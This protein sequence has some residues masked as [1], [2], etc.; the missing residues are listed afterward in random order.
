MQRYIYNIHCL[1]YD[2]SEKFL[3]RSN[4]IF[5]TWILTLQKS[6][7]RYPRTLRKCR[8]CSCRNNLFLENWIEIVTSLWPHVT[9]IMIITITSTSST[10]NVPRYIFLKFYTEKFFLEKLLQIIEILSSE[11]NRDKFSHS[12]RKDL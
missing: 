9:L 3:F 4:N 5:I 2:N 11:A 10:L 7:D 8:N 1:P 12:H 6:F